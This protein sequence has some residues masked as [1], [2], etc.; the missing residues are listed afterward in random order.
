[1]GALSGGALPAEPLALLRLGLTIAPGEHRAAVQ[2]P[3]ETAYPATPDAP[4]V[5][6]Y[7]LGEI[8]VVDLRGNHITNLDP[9][10]VASIRNASDREP[11]I[12]QLTVQSSGDSRPVA[13]GEQVEQGTSQ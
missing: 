7:R 1:M 6:K 10:R 2:L 8:A 4:D 3:A 5:C 12:S 9:S 13:R 11:A